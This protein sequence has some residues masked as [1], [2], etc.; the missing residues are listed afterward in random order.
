MVSFS[1]QKTLQI[2]RD[3]YSCRCVDDPKTTNKNV[4]IELTNRCNFNCD[5]C[6][7]RF[8]KRSKRFMSMRLLEKALKD[9]KNSGM[10]VSYVMFSHLG[11]P[12]LHPKFREACL[13]VKKYGFRLVVTT[14]GSL[15]NGGVN[16]LPIDELYI[17]FH[18]P[19]KKS[20][21]LRHAGSM[22]FYDYKK[23]VMNFAASSRM[24]T[25]IYLFKKN[26]TLPRLEGFFD[27]KS[28]KSVG[29]VERIVRNICP[30]FD[31]RKSYN[32]NESPIPL[33]HNLSLRFRNLQSFCNTII[34]DGMVV[35]DA[36]SIPRCSCYIHH[37]N[38]LSD[39]TVTFCCGD[40]DG[41]MS[42]GNIEKEHLHKI[43]ARRK[44]GADLSKYPFCRRCR[45]TLVSAGNLRTQPSLTC[46]R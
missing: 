30:S 22:K 25:C 40:M 19:N 26:D 6:Y 20:F 46:A 3:F 9:L 15:L 42:T 31:V 14:N 35:V 38:I 36:S 16:D 12:M 17:S 27:I 5:F 2:C 32:E 28:K 43:Y 11:E 18:T 41:S 13:L 24:P 21:K 29:E 4:F 23:S 39:G 45:G 37:I 44:P 8:S 33:S 10:D 1:R 7:Y 34:P